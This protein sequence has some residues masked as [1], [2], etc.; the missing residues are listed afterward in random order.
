MNLIIPNRILYRA[1]SVAICLVGTVPHV[2]HGQDR[3]PLATAANPTQ[4]VQPESDP[5]EILRQLRQRD[6]KGALETLSAVVDRGVSIGDLAYSGLPAAVAGLHRSLVQMSA[7]ERYELLYQWSFPEG[8]ADGERERVRII[9]IAVPTDGPPKVFARSI[10]E[11][12]RDSTFAIASIGPVRGFC[13]SGWMLVQAADELG[14]LARLRSTLEKLA[15]SKVD[16]AQELLML[17]YLAGRRGELDRVQAFLQQDIAEQGG[18]APSGLQPEDM[19]KAAIASAALLHEALQPLGESLLEKLVDQA[20]VGNSIALRPVLRIAHATAAQVHRGQSPPEVLFRNPLKHWVPA[21]VRSASD[22]DR[23]RPTAVWLTHEDHVLHLAGGTADVLFCRFPI[24]GEFDFVCETQEG[25]AIGTDG[26]LVYG[27]LQ[28]QALG[29]TNTL[30]VW[31]ADMNQMVTKPSPFARHDTSPVFNRVSIRS[32]KDGSNFESN[33]HPVWFDGSAAHSSPWLGLRS[34]GT[35]RP[36]FRNI[37]LSGKPVIPR[38]VRL[39]DG[40][41]LRGWQSGFFGETQPGFQSRLDAIEAGDRKFDWRIESG[42]LICARA[43][44][45][46]R[47]RKTRMASVPTPAARWRSDRL[48][49]P[50]RQRRCGCPSHDRPTGVLTG[51]DRRPRPLGHDREF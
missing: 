29:R 27:G 13:C 46:E 4:Q 34:S 43:G 32:S 23:G 41:Q 10:G 36:V 42:E 39:T 3:Q 16:G 45:R 6:A 21:T 35:K 5:A 17:A 48:R 50:A 51:T 1:V 15:E 24:I 38:E 22:I 26:G 49:V 30:T 8:D 9:A 44:R 12:P 31:D 25:G 11:R 7:D 40:D 20:R 33:F 47:H 19:T 14:R 28:F 37:R 2:T 18:E